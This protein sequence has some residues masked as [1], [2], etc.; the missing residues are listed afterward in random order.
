MIAQWALMQNAEGL[1]LNFY[2]PATLTAALPSGNR[3]TL[4]EETLYP[5]DGRVKITVSAERPEDFTLALRVPRWSKKTLVKVDGKPVEG[6]IPGAYLPIRIA[7]GSTQCALEIGFDFALHFWA[8]EKECADRISIYRGPLLYAYD[9][10]YNDLNPEQLPKIDWASARLEDTAWNGPI[11]PWGL[12]TLKDKNGAGFLVCDFS[13]AGQT[14]N[15]YRS[16]L[17]ADHM[18]PSPFNIEEP[19]DGG[20]GTTFRWEKRAGAEQWTLLIAHTRDF[21]EATRIEA[22]ENP[23]A[24]PRLKAGEYFWTVA[25]S[26]AHG[27]TEAA[28]GPRRV[29]IK[30]DAGL[31]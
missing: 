8:G 10:R 2:G 20:A 5:V 19:A 1:A 6:A 14:G 22:H 17:P 25:A 23:E 29:I 28:N 24:S 15:H 21:A 26:N 4:K 31:E 9:G 30:S 16:W 13:S 27:S 11:E 12:A 3:V 7:G 18:P